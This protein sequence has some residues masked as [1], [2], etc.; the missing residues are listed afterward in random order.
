M[1]GSAGTLG[2]PIPLLPWAEATNLSFA[3]M[4]GPGSG[5]GWGHMPVKPCLRGLAGVAQP[6]PGHCPCGEIG[7]EA[8]SGPRRKNRALGD[9]AAPLQ[10]TQCGLLPGRSGPGTLPAA[11]R[12]AMLTCT[13][14][15]TLGPRIPQ[16]DISDLRSVGAA[17]RP[18]LLPVGIWAGHQGPGQELPQP[19]RSQLRPSCPH[20]CPLRWPMTCSTWPT[21]TCCPA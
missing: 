2:S 7:S 5:L 20:S 14:D 6:C 13:S 9:I 11:F 18:P 17:A 19:G 1:G 21:C 3:G 16:P 10:G 15:R 12:E 4:I 8:S